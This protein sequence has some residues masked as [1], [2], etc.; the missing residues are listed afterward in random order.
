MGLRATRLVHAGLF[1]IDRT[2]LAPYP[3]VAK[4][5]RFEGPREL[6]VTLRSGVTFHGGK[7][8]DSTD[9]VATLAAFAD[10]KVGS[11][12]ARV[13]SAIARAE[14]E[15]PLGVKIVLSR[16]HATLLTDL[17]LPILRADQAAAPPAPDGTLDGLGP[18]EITRAA[19]GVIDLSPRA[20]G[21]F[22]APKHALTLR[23]VRDE[24]AR[25]LRL[26]AGRAD[27][28]QNG[29]SP[30]L[31]PSFDRAGL[32]VVARPSASL[33]YLV[34]R[35][36]RGIMQDARVR[37]AVSLAVDRSMLV[38]T[39]FAGHATP[40][41]TLLPPGHWARPHVP[42][43]GP[44]DVEGARQLVREAGAMG[45]RVS[46]LVSTD[47]ARKLMARILAAAL[48]EVGLLVETTS[49]ELGTMLG[50]LGSGDFELAMLQLPEVIEPNVLRVFLHGDFVPP[51]GSNRGRVRS[52]RLDA[53]LD[54]GDAQRDDDARRA[55][56]AEVETLVREEALW[57]PLVHE[58][59]VAVVS[60]RA[61][62]YAPDRDGRWGGLFD[63]P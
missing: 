63:L 31:L 22:P 61:S 29:F 4:S 41:S 34:P 10:L 2:T 12:H 46:L 5:Y 42:E 15:G 28:V 49:L 47:R 32:Q 60:P 9:V 3:L 13:V 25:A 45:A 38:R 6:H 33:T 30:T 11:R 58:D 14:P 35:C 8:L 52:A 21:V 53:L 17:E 43:A 36:D 40:A 56:Y 39:L 1:G 54:A 51:A 62:A 7:A 59:H 18:F 57:I 23:A 19:G 24:N 44:R 55:L 20:T 37:R 26:H 48:E 27:L 16:P 50:R